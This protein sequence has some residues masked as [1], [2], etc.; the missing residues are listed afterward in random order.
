M[1]TNTNITIGLNIRKFASDVKKASK[2]LSKL[3]DNKVSI[4][5]DDKD[6]KKFS[7]FS[8]ETFDKLKKK[9]EEQTTQLRGIQSLKLR[10]ARESKTLDDDTIRREE[11]LLRLR[12]LTTKELEQQ[13]KHFKAG[14]ALQRRGARMRMQGGGIRSGIGGAIQGLG[15]IA[16]KMGPLGMVAGLGM[17]AYAGAR[18]ITAP[19]RELAEQNLQFMGLNRGDRGVIGGGDLR[20]LR[21]SGIS[22]G[23]RPQEQMQAANLLQR[24]VGDVGRN[25]QVMTQFAQARRTTGLGAEDLAGVMGGFRAAAT[26]AGGAQLAGQGGTLDKTMK[27]YKQAMIS[28]LDSSGTIKFMQKTAE[29]TESMANEGTADVKAIQDTLTQLSLSSTFFAANVNRGAVAMKGGEA[30]FTSPEGTGLALR[31]LRNIPNKKLRAKFEKMSAPELLLQIQRGFT[32]EG[33]LGSEGLNAI[34]KELAFAATGVKTA[35]AFTGKPDVRAAAELSIQQKFGFND[36]A[37]A[38]E[39]LNAALKNTDLSKEQKDKLENLTQTEKQKLENIKGSLDMGIKRNEANFHTLIMAVGEKV[40]GPLTRMEGWVIGAAKKMLGI[41]TRKTTG[42]LGIEK[43]ILEAKAKE[44]GGGV[45]DWIKSF[46]GGDVATRLTEK[47]REIVGAKV[48]EGGGLK[49]FT[50]SNQ[51]VSNVL[52]FEDTPRN[53]GKFGRGTGRFRSLD[54]SMIRNKMG[55]IESAQTTLGEGMASRRE[56]LQESGAT[57]EKIKEAML[58]DSAAMARLEEISEMFHR[59]LSNLPSKSVNNYSK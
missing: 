59:L 20:R 30:F 9:A 22:Q 29:M 55:D 15:G 1:A 36:P 49:G 28:A 42:E 57:P 35:E 50:E 53:L 5:I 14:N 41:E 2:E 33:G 31:A 34:T 11:K 10:L 21:E 7:K 23:F 37:L 56:R 24:N 40:A 51:F 58:A 16:S 27:L 38:K 26:T 48:S 32:R 17:A 13:R 19:R 54:R 44:E 12:K 25:A 47:D 6:L 8:I 3:G 18:A 43:N 39:L 4:S 52:G 46:Y 45:I